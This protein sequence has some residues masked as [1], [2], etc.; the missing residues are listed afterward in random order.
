MVDSSDKVNLWPGFFEIYD[1]SSD[2]LA[3]DSISLRDAMRLIK[4]T[5]LF[6]M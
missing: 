2:G 3:N 4:I 5:E 1:D 6:A